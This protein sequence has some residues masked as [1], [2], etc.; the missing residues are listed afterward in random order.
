MPPLTIEEV[1]QRI[2]AAKS[3]KAP[4]DD[5]LPAMVWKHVWPVVKKRV[6]F[7]F[8]TSLDNGEIPT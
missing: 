2:F 1:E 7:L 5:R 3:W 4:G 8:Q 6:L